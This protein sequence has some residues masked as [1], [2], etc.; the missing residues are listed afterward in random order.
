MKN[1]GISGGIIEIGAGTGY[2]ASL[3]KD[4]GINTVAWDIRPPG[5]TKSNEY[6]GSTPEFCNVAKGDPSDLR[7][8]FPSLKAEADEALLLCYPPP[9]SPMA[10]EALEAY[11]A[12]GGKCLI[13]IGEFSGL[14]GSTAFE[15]LLVRHFYCVDRI[16]CLAWGTDA[17]MVT[18]WLRNSTDAGEA[19]ATLFGSMFR[20]PQVGIIKTMSRCTAPCVL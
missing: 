1:A 16:P 10:K 11:L 12:G 8:R 5:S 6:H 3:L 15:D 17:S 20:L 14:T 13:H 19:G 4:A 9:E 2:V 18:V 7:L